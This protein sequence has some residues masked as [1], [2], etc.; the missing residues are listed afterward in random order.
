[1]NVT[2]KHLHAFVAVAEEGSFT[3][4]ARRLALSQPA[5]TIQITQFEEEL[6]VR[7]FDRTTRRVLL[8]DNGAE[9][10]PT[11]RRLLEDVNSAIAEVR[12]VAARRRGRVGVATLPSVSVKLM[13]QMVAA[14]RQDYPGVSVQLVDANASGVQ[15]R[16]RRKEVDFGIASRW[17]PDDD[18]NFETVMRDP[19]H[20]VCR[21]DHPLA[22]A[23]GTLSWDDLAGQEF[24]GLAPDTGI[25]PLIE[26]VPDLP[27]NV[28][29]PP[30]EVS[31]IA[32]LE[33]MLIAG[34]GIT[35]LPELALPE[36]PEGRLIARPLQ[37]PSVSRALCL[38]TRRGRSLSPAAQSLRDLIVSRLADGPVAYPNV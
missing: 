2:F 26:S 29:Q 7:L 13:P 34:L 5:L 22:Q 31:N 17:T 27:A 8:T 36:D 4:A 20:V 30:V 10:L 24:L 19:F 3:R 14:F 37:G 12:D 15:A 35:V 33:G 1:M 25:R 11:A 16:V 38:I 6:G 21:R 23:T 9:F 18:L 32:T 28:R